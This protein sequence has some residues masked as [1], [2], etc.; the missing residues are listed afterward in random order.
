MDQECGNVFQVMMKL[1]FGFWNLVERKELIDDLKF[2]G[3]DWK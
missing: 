2:K 3:Y 1:C